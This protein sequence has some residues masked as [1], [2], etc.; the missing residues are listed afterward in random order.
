MKRSLDY[1]NNRRKLKQLRNDNVKYRV[2]SQSAWEWFN[3]LN[4]QIFGNKLAPVDK[5][6]ISNHKGDDVYAFYYY[7]TKN[8]PKHGQTSISFLKTFKDEK[9]FVEILGHEMVHHFQHLYNEPSGHGPTFEAWG[10]NFKLKGL[11]LHKVA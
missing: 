10:D 2:T 9:F 5:I 11:K 4:E 8:D 1:Y 7:Y 3:I 6:Y